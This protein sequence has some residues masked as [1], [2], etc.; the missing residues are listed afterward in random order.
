MS[1]SWQDNLRSV[2]RESLAS[3]IPLR[4]GLPWVPVSSIAQQFYCE[5]KV[6]HEYRFGKIPT[7]EKEEGTMLHEEI[8]TMKPTTP[9]DLV[10]SIEKEPI[11]LCT[12]PVFGK[13]DDLPIF[14]IPDAVLFRKSVLSHLIELK[15]TNGDVSRLWRDQAVQVKAYALALDL[16]GFDCAK[17][18]L[19]LVRVS[20]SDISGEGKESLLNEVTKGLLDGRIDAVEQSLRQRMRAEVKVHRLLYDR[21]DAAKDV[22]WAK[23]YWLMKRGPIPTRNARKCRVCEFNELCP[24]SMTKN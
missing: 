13:V 15:T 1:T 5:V 4:F 9:S 6:D 21:Q 7:P 3:K 20:K 2:D 23:D 17:L 19:S 22:A 12:F 10:R 24:F 8:I 14:G 18:E 11:C 16:M